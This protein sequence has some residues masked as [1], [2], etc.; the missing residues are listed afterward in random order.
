MRRLAALLVFLTACG[1]TVVDDG[2]CEPGLMGCEPLD[3]YWCYDGRPSPAGVCLDTVGA[4]QDVE[5]C[6]PY[7]DVVSDP[8]EQISNRR[9]C[10]ASCENNEDCTAAATGL[11][12]DLRCLEIDGTPVCGLHDWSDQWPE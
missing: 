10:I 3:G 12:H 4:S 2:P 9:F 5:S 6:Q 7:A 11:G 1:P 8:V